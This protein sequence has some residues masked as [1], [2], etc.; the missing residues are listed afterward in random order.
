MLNKN[1]SYVDI[2]KA[3]TLFGG[4]QLFNIIV[5][6]IRSKLIAVLLG[7]SGMG[8]IGLFSSAIGL[9]S[10]ITGFGLGTS[11][12]KEIA[13]AENIQDKN[14]I[15]FISTVIKKIMLL[16]GVFGL[17]FTLFFSPILSQFT[18]NNRNYTLS[19]AILSIT[20]L[21][22]QLNSSNLVFLQGFRKLKEL[23]KSNLYGSLFS[24]LL[25]IPLFYY[26]KENGIVS[27]LVISSI[28]TYI[29]SNIYVRKIK[30]Q[31][32]NLSLKTVLFEGRNMLK[33]G[34]L[35]N[36]SSLLT[37]GASYLVRIYVSNAGGFEQVGLYN[38]GFAIINTYFGLI[39]TAMSTDY[40][41][42]L[43]AVSNNKSEYNKLINQQAEI[44]ILIISPILLFFIIFIKLIIFL[45]YTNQFI[46]AYDMIIWAS[47]GMFFKTATWA[48][49]FLLL[50]KSSSKL[51]FISELISN[52]LL[53]ILNILSYKYFGLKGLGISFLASYIVSLA[54]VLL[55]TYKFYDFE[56]DYDF[57][58]I[59][60][61][62]LFLSLL[63]LFVLYNLKGFILYFSGIILISISLFY[64]FIQLNKRVN[65]INFF[66]PINKE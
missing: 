3:T 43:A 15:V 11:A 32:A 29:F 2:L 64:S 56:L 12:V 30:I 7:P 18:F 5:Q 59:F 57:I 1:K 9:I 6:I 8:V 10:G 14:R 51:Y 33:M 55:I 40:Y 28:I 48:I 53:L 46:A 23:A 45:L 24:L 63:C 17:V 65:L 13:I 34:F 41:P 25:T 38:A 44:A 58:K 61:I 4:V 37:V 31:S 21:F 36:L 26:F 50:A 20:L 42:R 39:L 35:I 27:G 49:G 62:H 52:I 47:I 22:I 16:T 66:R 19:F 60:L 54:Q